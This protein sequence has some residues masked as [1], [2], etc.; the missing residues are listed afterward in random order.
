MSFS[1]TSTG[2]APADPYKTANLDNVDLKTKVEDL[3]DF[4]TKSKFAMMTTR[5]SSGNLVSRCMAVA[6]TETGGIDLLFHTNTESGKT[7]DLAADSHVNIAFV[8]GSG[9]WASIA[10]NATIST[11][12]DLI[13][14]HYS[15]TLKA[16]LGDLGDGKHDGSKNDPRLGIIRVRTV[17]ATY[18]LS[19]K[20]LFSRAAEIATSTITGSP[21]QINRIREITENEVGTWRTTA[22]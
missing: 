7:D 12:R 9:E 14:E 3:A 6:A 20:N 19:A 15:P 18:M 21:P 5:S 8:N 16:W 10:G 1:N 17:S 13:A 22:S 11:N 2:D 4:M